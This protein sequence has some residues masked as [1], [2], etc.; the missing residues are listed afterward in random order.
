M[1]GVKKLQVHVGL[2]VCL[3]SQIYPVIL[4]LRRVRSVCVS[5]CVRMLVL[6]RSRGVEAKLF[7]LG[8]DT[9]TDPVHTL[10]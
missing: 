5:V 1:K 3:H 4:T 9:L 7:F 8:V 2:V 10:L 6:L